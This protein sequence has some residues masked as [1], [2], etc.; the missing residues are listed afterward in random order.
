MI[1]APPCGLAE[2]KSQTPQPQR[3]CFEDRPENNQ[4]LN[5]DQGNTSVLESRPL[6][7]C[8]CQHRSMGW[9]GLQAE[10]LCV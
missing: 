7:M 1:W 2:Q 10:N 5:L 9:S 6:E 3:V 4:V 8:L